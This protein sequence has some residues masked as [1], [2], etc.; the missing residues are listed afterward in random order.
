M[1]REEQLSEV[2][3]EFARTMVTDFPNQAILDHLA[4]ITAEPPC[5]LEVA[6]TRLPEYG[7]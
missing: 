2:L 3:S 7:S 1:A 4:A 6:A 5:P